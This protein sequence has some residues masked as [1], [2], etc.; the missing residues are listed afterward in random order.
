MENT[1]SPSLR[2]TLY[3]KHADLRSRLTAAEDI[4]FELAIYRRVTEL[5]L[6][7]RAMEK[8]PELACLNTAKRKIIE[9]L[10]EA[11]LEGMHKSRL[12][13]KLYDS[14]RYIR[15]EALSQLIADNIVALVVRRS[16]SGKGRPS[17]RY[18]IVT[19]G[20]SLDKV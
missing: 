5:R 7:L 16:E 10:S 12:H 2:Q 18:Y 17:E 20:Y 4:L 14:D 8:D 1:K 15:E 19:P 3:A 6:E 11:H 9:W 13:M